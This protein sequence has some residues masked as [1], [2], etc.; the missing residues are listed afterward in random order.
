MC[1]AD[2]SLTCPNIMIIFHGKFPSSDA[3]KLGVFMRVPPPLLQDYSRN[4]PG[5]VDVIMMDILNYWLNTDKDKSGRKLA[6]AMEMCDQLNLAEEIRSRITVVGKLRC[7]L[8]KFRC[9]YKALLL[10]LQ[11]SFFLF[12]D[13]NEALEILSNRTL[14]F[15]FIHL[16]FYYHILFLCISPFIFSHFV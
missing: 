4:N 3:D 9:S 15:M 13:L 11:C 14:L 16:L 10:L 8:G 5:H 6:G 1:D 2:L 12:V 7:V